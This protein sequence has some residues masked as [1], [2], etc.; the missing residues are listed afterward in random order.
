MWLR[1]VFKGWLGVLVGLLM[2]I[3]WLG[4]KCLLE[5]VVHYDAGMYWGG[6]VEILYYY[7]KKDVN[8]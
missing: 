8:T 7:Y 5:V 2:I 4:R 3:W 6:R 1:F